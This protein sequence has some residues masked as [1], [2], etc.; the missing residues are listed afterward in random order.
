MMTSTR[1]L[2]IGFLAACLLAGG[3]VGYVHAACGSGGGGCFCDQNAG[4]GCSVTCDYDSCI[5]PAKCSANDS[6]HACIPGTWYQECTV[7]PC[8]GNCD[9]NSGVQ[10]SCPQTNGLC[11]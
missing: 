2:S 11:S 6:G 7:K 10:C 3:V 8:D 1:Y 4:T 9:D 5:P